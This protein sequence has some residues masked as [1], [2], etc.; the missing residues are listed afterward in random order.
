[1][2]RRQIRKEYDAFRRSKRDD[3][4]WIFKGNDDSK[5]HIHI[6]GP[7]DTPY[8]GGVFILH[9]KVGGNYPFR[10]PTVRMETKI[11]HININRKG[12]ICLALF[13]TG[14]KFIPSYGADQ[15]SSIM[16]IVDEV[17]D[18]LIDPMESDII[19]MDAAVLFVD[20]KEKYIQT[21]K[22]WTSQYAHP[23]Q[24][25]NSK[26]SKKSET[27][28]NKLKS[29]RGIENEYNHSEM[30][31]P[32][33]QTPIDKSQ[34]V[35]DKNVIGISRVLEKFNSIKNK[36]DS[37][38]SSANVSSQNLRQVNA[39][40][41]VSDDS[42]LDF[43]LPTY[44]SGFS[45][46]KSK[47]QKNNTNATK[48]GPSDAKETSV[49]MLSQLSFGADFVNFAE[50]G[51]NIGDDIKTSQMKQEF[52]NT[53]I[54][55]GGSNV[56]EIKINL[57]ECDIGDGDSGSARAEVKHDD[58]NK[59]GDFTDVSLADV[60]LKHGKHLLSFKLIDATYGKCIAMID[61]EKC[62]NVYSLDKRKWIVKKLKSLKPS[63]NDARALV[64][65]MSNDES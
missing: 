28:Q 55:I 27:S 8:A 37:A 20:D 22:E 45:T 32:N 64:V 16:G 9:F 23:R 50:I 41:T 61:K 43:D 60:G 11:F 49:E 44:T 10:A 46:T 13:D 59:D 30:P 52:A 2:S 62:Y 42:G 6:H 7:E 29:Q 39:L 36:R 1:M 19:N 47:N 53:M 14:W 33:P 34:P 15:P 40:S 17:I 54:I 18:H 35:S 5:F 31:D 57:I 65:L 63:T 12:Q 4:E 24:H 56:D 25:S 48:N 21:A 58:D 3:C 51:I 26:K 38:N